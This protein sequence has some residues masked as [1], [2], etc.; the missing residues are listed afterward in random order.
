MMH[1]HFETK[2][3]AC[4]VNVGASR[5]SCSCS[6]V[7]G[8]HPLPHDKICLLGNGR[9]AHFGEGVSPIL[10]CRNCVMSIPAVCAVLEWESLKANTCW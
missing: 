9:T 1:V 3:E 5:N 10:L 7:R 6:A 8:G 4:T 2:Q